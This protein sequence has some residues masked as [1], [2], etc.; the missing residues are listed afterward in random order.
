MATMRT[1]ALAA[2]I[3]ALAA[4]LLLNACDTQASKTATGVSVEE[5]WV[6]L[7]AVPGRPGAAYFRI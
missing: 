7:P 2:S 1:T 4:V 3:A 5:A 6:R